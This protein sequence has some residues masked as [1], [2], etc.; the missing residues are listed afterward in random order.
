MRHEDLHRDLFEGVVRAEIGGH[1][2]KGIPSTSP[3]EEKLVKEKEKLMT[4]GFIK[5]GIPESRH[6]HRIA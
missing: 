3:Y 1:R 5:R 4:S 2:F 6:V